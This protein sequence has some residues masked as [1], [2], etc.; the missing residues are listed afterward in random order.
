MA[1]Y[2]GPRNRLARREGADLAHKTVGSKS[3]AG[4]LRRLNITPG[5]QGG[6]YRRSQSNYAVQLRE[7]QKAKRLY[8]V[9][10][11]Q[12]RRYF[13]IAATKKGQTGA[14]LL[15]QLELRLDNVI[16]RLGL[17]P[18]RSAA[19]QMVSHRHVMVNDGVVNI[20][21]Y[22]LQV[23]D[24]ITLKPKATEIPATVKLLKEKNPIVPSWLV[25]KAATGKVAKVPDRE[26]IDLD[27]NEQLIVEYYSR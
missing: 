11:R 17:A 13:E 27:V 25:R 7:K 5:Q 14:V 20:P 22:Q 12:F 3:H 16:Y 8:G 1:R 24:V 15:Q 10:E 2:T 21:S 9:L 23:D 19:R 6:K 26:E 4:L 18:T